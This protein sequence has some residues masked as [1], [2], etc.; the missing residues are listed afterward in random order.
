MAVDGM[1]LSDSPSESRQSVLIV[2][3][4]RS[5]DRCRPVPARNKLPRV[6]P[7]HDVHRFPHAFEAQ[8]IHCLLT[9]CILLVRRVPRTNRPRVARYAVDE[10]RARTHGSRSDRP[11]IECATHS[12]DRKLLFD[13]LQLRRLSETFADH[14]FKQVFESPKLRYKPPN[15]IYVLDQNRRTKP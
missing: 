6:R 10:I 15:T 4:G 13:L 12:P 3:A 14:S 11:G 2:D 5:K 9:L 1:T 8:E 7:S